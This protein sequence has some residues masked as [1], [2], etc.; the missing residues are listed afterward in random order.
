MTTPRLLGPWLLLLVGVA[1][2]VVAVVSGHLRAGGYLL[3]GALGVTAVVRAVLPTSAVGAVAVRSKAVDVLL[4]AGAAGAAA[5][6]A[7]TVKLTV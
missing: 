4:L 2:A 5:V 6:L 1:A 3:A 7:A